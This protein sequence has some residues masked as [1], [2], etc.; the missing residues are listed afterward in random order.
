MK[1]KTIIWAVLMLLTFITA[2]IS[3]RAINDAL[4]LIIGIADLK[5]IL[6]TFEFMELKK[7]HIL[8]KYLVLG[9]LTIFSSIV[10]LIL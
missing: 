4:L 9:F 8:W 6:V 2:F 5:F 1:N 7:A 3:K 10:L